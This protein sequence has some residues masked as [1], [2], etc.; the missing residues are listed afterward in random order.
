MRLRRVLLRTLPL[1]LSVVGIVS[2]LVL[3]LFAPVAHA[4][5]N[6]GRKWVVNDEFGYYY[7]IKYVIDTDFSSSFR[8]RIFEGSIQW[9]IN[10]HLYFERQTAEDFRTDMNVFKTTS[11]WPFDQYCA[12][13][14]TSGSGGQLTGARLYFPTNPCGKSW[15]TGTGTPPTGTVDALSVAIHEFGHAVELHHADTPYTSKPASAMWPYVPNS[16]DTK[17][18]IIAWD[19]DG[20][21]AMYPAR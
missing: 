1:R 4:A 15:Y 11:T 8:S 10:T 21:R 16:P 13:A 19:K 12:Y 20:V 18:Y 7:R 6:M 5:D 17:R 14:Q 9:N 2:V 3:T